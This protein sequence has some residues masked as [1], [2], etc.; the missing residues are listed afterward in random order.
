MNFSAVILAGGQSS[1]MGRDKATV[2]L[3]GQTLLA[4]QIA[5]ARSVGATEIFIS[6]RR[7]ATYDV[8]GIRVVTDRFLNAGPLAGIERALA[9]M[10]TPQLLVLAVDMPRLTA[11]LLYRLAQACGNE[12]GVVPEICGRIEPLAAFY[13]R[14]A[15]DLAVRMLSEAQ[16]DS[17]H[18]TPGP[19]DFVRRG[20]TAGMM[21][22]MPL[23]DAE[24]DLFTNVNSPGDLPPASMLRPQ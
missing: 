16:S 8:A 2:E 19:A 21:R 1:R 23:S 3:G 15:H 14:R 4:R 18:R 6:G 5:L 7:G 24:A 17:S 20:M 10:V 12:G 11:E 13:P 22:Q 9:E